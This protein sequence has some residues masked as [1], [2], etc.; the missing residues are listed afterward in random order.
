MQIRGPVGRDWFRVR[1]AVQQSRGRRKEGRF[2]SA[3]WLRPLRAAASHGRGNAKESPDSASPPC[4]RWSSPDAARCGT[5]RH[6]GC[7]YLL[8][9]SSRILM[10]RKATSLP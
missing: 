2:H 8:S 6:A 3:L 1:N 5:G 10:L 4:W 9:G 7:A